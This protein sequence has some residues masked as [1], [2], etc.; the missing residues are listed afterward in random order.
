[1]QYQRIEFTINPDGSITEKVID[2]GTNC[3]DTTEGLEKAIGKVILREMLPETQ[4][5]F[6]PIDMNEDLTQW[7]N[8]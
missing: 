7:Q 4:T 3:I 8:K 2:A 6:V 1:M 5:S